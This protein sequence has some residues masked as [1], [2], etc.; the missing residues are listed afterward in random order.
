MKGNIE[1]L[2]DASKAVGPQINT[3]EN[4]YMLLSRR[5]NVG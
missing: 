5:K 3:E 2:I 1:T 4:K